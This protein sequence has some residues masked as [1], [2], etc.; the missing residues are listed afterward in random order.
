MDKVREAKLKAIKAAMTQFNK[1]MA[2]KSDGNG[3]D[4]VIDL[5][6]HEQKAVEV[7]STGS[8]MFDLALG[9]GGF[10]KGR[11]IELYGAESSGKTLIATK[12]AGECQKA[13]GV[14]GIVDMEHTFDP[15][16]AAK[17]G[18]DCTSGV[19]LTQPAHLQEAFTVVDKMIDAGFDLVILDSVAALVPQEELENDIGK[20]SVALVA[21][22]MSQFLR[23]ITAKA[24][25]NSCSVI[26]INQVRDAI[27]QMYGD[28]TTTPGGKA[29][30][31]Y[32]SV[33]IM[34]SKV[35]GSN[36]TQKIGG[37]DVVIGHSI[38]TNVKK[39]KVA[40]PFRKAEFVVYYDGREVDKVQELA[41]VALLKGLIPKYDAAGNIS[42]TGRTYK[43]PS[44]PN[45]IAKKKDE[46]ADELR[47]Y[48]NVQ[49]ELINI[50]KG[51]LED[52]TAVF[53]S[54][55]FDSDMT[56]EEFEAQMKADI[57]KIEKGEDSEAEEES[58][59]WDEI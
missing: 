45:F 48:P 8:L 43:W 55:D 54:K 50:L 1:E 53:E 9:V 47:K 44:E 16:F 34:V 22:Y 14:I 11:L 18:L 3:D 7:F 26:F 23:R 25:K 20:Q 29:L 40:P 5:G 46:V 12:A 30:K 56:E 42:P 32:C 37:E 36:I 24:A 19:Y 52:P 33:R 35:G 4:L 31:F 59:G 51:G 13:G 21:R 2:K 28:P 27:G 6:Q 49:E 57:E 15:A 39:N 10:P 17:L 38:R 41:T 58:G